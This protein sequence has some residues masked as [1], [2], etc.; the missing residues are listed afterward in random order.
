MRALLERHRGAATARAPASEKTCVTDRM[1]FCIRR[2]RGHGALRTPSPVV[3]QQRAVALLAPSRASLR[4]RCGQLRAAARP[5]NEKRKGAAACASE[6]RTRRNAAPGA[7]GSGDNEAGTRTPAL[8]LRSTGDARTHRT[9]D[10]VPLRLFGPSCVRSLHSL[11]RRCGA[12]GRP[13]AQCVRRDATPSPAAG[14]ALVFGSS[15]R[16]AESLPA[17]ADVAH[18][19][20]LQTTLPTPRSAPLRA[21]LRAPRSRSAPRSR[22][23]LLRCSVCSERLPAAAMEATLCRYH[24]GALG[25]RDTAGGVGNSSGDRAAAGGYAGGAVW[26]CCGA[27][28]ANAPGCAAGCHVPEA[29]EASGGSG[30]GSAH[31]RQASEGGGGQDDDDSGGDGGDSERAPPPFIHVVVGSADTLAG[32]AVRHNTTP[33]A[34]AHA[35][36]LTLQQQGGLSRHRCSPRAR[37]R[38]RCAATRAFSRALRSRSCARW[39]LADARASAHPSFPRLSRALFSAPPQAILLANGLPCPFAFGSR[40]V[41]RIP[42]GSAPLPPTPVRARASLRRHAT[43]ITPLPHIPPRASTHAHAPALRLP[44]RRSRPRAPCCCSSSPPPRPRAAAAPPVWRRQ[45]PILI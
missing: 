42:T 12:R 11:A 1:T 4:R 10:S 25:N 22:M 28:G 44:C 31:K 29:P 7:G 9:Q 30:R 19:S 37:A 21:P 8:L 5:A 38:H 27:E 34:R 32:L 36:A 45:A 14:P 3:T 41:M 20:R 39:R 16:A 2:R 35:R 13:A 18:S 23:A 43:P 26:R 40:K 33:E 15:S 17:L 6:A 24:V